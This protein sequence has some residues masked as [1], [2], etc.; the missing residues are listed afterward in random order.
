[1][2]LLLVKWKSQ[3]HLLPKPY[4]HFRFAQ[5]LTTNNPLYYILDTSSIHWRYRLDLLYCMNFKLSVTNSALFVWL[6][7][8]HIFI[9]ILIKSN[10]TEHCCKC[11]C[12]ITT[13]E[14][15]CIVMFLVHLILISLCVLC[16]IK[17]FK[18]LLG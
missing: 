18:M 5:P 7:W 4:L 16:C 2:V 6:L 17:V 8:S 11:L 15:E 1:M 13:M 12:F 9:S 3:C 14:I 10:D